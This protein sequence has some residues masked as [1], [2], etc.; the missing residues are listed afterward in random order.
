MVAA[1]ALVTLQARIFASARMNSSAVVLAIGADC[2]GPSRC[3][4]G[5]AP[6]E[7]CPESQPGKFPD[8]MTDEVI[9]MLARITGLRVVS[10]TS[11]MQY[12]KVPSS[13][14]GRGAG[15]WSDGI[16]ERFHW[17]GGDPG[18]HESQLIYA[19]E[20]GISGGEFTTRLERT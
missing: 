16:L 11:V 8:G 7:I 15:A 14:V 17:A 18:A 2:E 10:R 3:I 12:K 1:L 19:P 5:C 4:P 13:A 20:T 6:L 9:T